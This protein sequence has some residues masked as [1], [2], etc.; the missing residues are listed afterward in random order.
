MTSTIFIEDAFLEFYKIVNSHGFHLN[1][2][3][4]SAASSFYNLVINNDQFT[5]NQSRFLMKI[6]E[7]YRTE[8]LALGI[9]YSAALAAPRWKNP[10]RTLDMTRSIWVEKDED[11][12]QW[13]VIKMPYALKDLM[14]KT[15]RPKEDIYKSSSWDK[16]RQVRKLKLNCFNIVQV[17]DFVESNGFQKQDSFLEVFSEVEQ[18]WQDQDDVI[19]SSRLIGDTV[20]LVNVSPEVSQWWDENK[21]QTV[22][23]KLFMAKTMGYPLI[24]EKSNIS[25]IEK[26][27]SSKSKDF[28]ISDIKT[29]FEIYKL[30]N[31]KVAIVVDRAVDSIQW[32]K[33]FVAQ[34]KINEIN[35]Q[36]IRV[37][38]RLAKD[39]DQGFNQWI[40][41]TELGGSV[42]HGKIFI[43]QN[44]PAKWL[45]N[46]SQDVKIV[47]TNSPYPIP[48]TITQDWI[49]S[50]QCVFHLGELKISQ[51]KD[52]NIVN[53]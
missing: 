1:G 31:V 19:P 28:R 46:G 24:L 2:N 38:F 21:P 48:S 10:F 18:I 17:N 34:A 6:L 32:I 25:I 43:F 20:E 12:T 3:D 53:L 33:Q 5:V 51:N 49:K 11:D 27:A 36:D 15:I 35:H 42:D 40:K 30:L 37:C 47:A 50:H 9:D 14:E 13:I 16:D 39:Q 23:E 52:N 41:D 4:I 44:K 45:F 8:A 22:P 29:F 26:I 7:K